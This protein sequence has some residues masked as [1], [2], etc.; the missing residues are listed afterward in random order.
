MTLN[1]HSAVTVITVLLSNCQSNKYSCSSSKHGSTRL[2]TTCLASR[3]MNSPF[4]FWSEPQSVS[5][6]HQ[7]PLPLSDKQYRTTC[8]WLGG[9]CLWPECPD[10]YLFHQ[11]QVPLWLQL[12]IKRTWRDQT[13][14]RKPGL[15]V[16]SK[17]S[18]VIA[19]AIFI[20]FF[21]PFCKYLWSPTT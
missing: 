20:D 21:S 13:L 3:I 14:F 8:S 9:E 16:C 11:G 18:C 7:Q 6:F 2:S 1:I 5:S 19:G 10:N 15:T 17:E 12:Y 4:Y